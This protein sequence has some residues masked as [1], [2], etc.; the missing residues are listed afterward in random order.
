[1]VAKRLWVRLVPKEEG[2]KEKKKKALPMGTEY[3]TLL[4]S[5]ALTSSL[6]DL[7]ELRTTRMVEQTSWA[8]THRAPLT[9]ALPHFVLV[10]LLVPDVLYC[11][12]D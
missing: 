8:A 6:S 3:E 10:L 11:T 9:S 5:I 1:M 7:F 2:E 12:V 4:Q